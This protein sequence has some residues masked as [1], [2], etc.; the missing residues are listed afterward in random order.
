VTKCQAV[1]VLSANKSH[2]V[3]IARWLCK[4]L[5]NF[6]IIKTNQSFTGAD[7][8]MKMLNKCIKIVLKFHAVSEKASK[9]SRGLLFSATLCITD[10]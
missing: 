6:T 1:T 3:K 9:N 8:L 4:R 7:M 10:L 2:S 5:C